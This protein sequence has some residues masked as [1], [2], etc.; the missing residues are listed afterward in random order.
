MRPGRGSV[1]PSSRSAGPTSTTGPAT[2]TFEQSTYHGPGQRSAPIPRQGQTAPSGQLEL[3][4]DEQLTATQR[5]EQFHHR[6]PVV[7]RTLVALA[8]EWV[9]RTG[10][11]RLGIATMYERCRWDLALVTDSDDYDVN[12]DYKADYARLIMKQEPDL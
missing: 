1:S 6:N 11:R 10:K 5:F 4:F 7:Y 9:R 3:R 8:R 2:E 12:N